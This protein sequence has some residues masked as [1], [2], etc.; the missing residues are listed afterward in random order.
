MIIKVYSKKGC[1]KC[2]SAKKNIKLMGFEFEE[3]SALY[4][5]ELHNGWK[6]NN[7][8]DFKSL[9]VMTEGQLPIIDIDGRCY[10]YSEAM[11]KLKELKKDKK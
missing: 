4:H 8:V 1:E 2:D 3:H 7:S 5:G 9:S 6:E 11:L 10:S